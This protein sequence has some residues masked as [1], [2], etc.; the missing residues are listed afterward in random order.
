[1][2]LIRKLNKCNHEYFTVNFANV[3]I[4]MGDKFCAA[5]LDD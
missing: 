2:S 5:G 3:K 1:M 4:L